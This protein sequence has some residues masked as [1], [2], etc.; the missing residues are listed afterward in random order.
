[1]LNHPRHRPSPPGPHASPN[2]NS[3]PSKGIQSIPR[4]R[5]QPR[6][7]AGGR[8]PPDT[9]SHPTTGTQADCAS[10]ESVI[11]AMVREHAP[12]ALLVFQVACGHRI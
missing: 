10:V 1:M 6:S 4:S 12:G 11:R 8:G 7:T 5:S 9:F 2:R 3:A